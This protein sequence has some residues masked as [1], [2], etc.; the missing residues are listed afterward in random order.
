MSN[1]GISIVSRLTACQILGQSLY[2]IR[3]T[4]GCMI[5]LEALLSLAGHAYSVI[6]L[7][8]EPHST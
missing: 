8:Q 1:P 5:T 2:S 6:W 4:N 3:S 7:Q